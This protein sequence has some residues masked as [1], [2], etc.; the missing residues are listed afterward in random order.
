MN[1]FHLAQVRCFCRCTNDFAVYD[2]SGQI[3]F[4]GNQKGMS[5]MGIFLLTITTA[6]TIQRR[7]STICW[8]ENP[9]HRIRM[10]GAQLL[11]NRIPSHR[12]IITMMD[13]IIRKQR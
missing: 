4:V 1:H 8:P 5:K 3:V 13:V 7:K 6:G 10:H 12:P 11:G 2:G 9:E